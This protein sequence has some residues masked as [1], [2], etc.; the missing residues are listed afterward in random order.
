M[1]NPSEYDIYLIACMLGID[2][3]FSTRYAGP[4]SILSLPEI[5]CL[6]Q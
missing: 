5:G 3:L 2:K 6:T 4:V 1:N